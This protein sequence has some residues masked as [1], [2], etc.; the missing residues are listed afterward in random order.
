MPKTKRRLTKR[1]RKAIARSRAADERSR[2]LAPIAAIEPEAD[3]DDVPCV[4]E[5]V[6]HVGEHVREAGLALFQLVD[7]VHAAR[8]EWPEAPAV[9]ELRTLLEEIERVATECHEALHAAYVRCDTLLETAPHLH[10]VDNQVVVVAHDAT[11]STST[12]ARQGVVTASPPSISPIPA[13]RLA[14]E[15]ADVD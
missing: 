10:L 1:E 7:V 4:H 5:V 13:A 3:S 6:G 8:S 11:T 15:L 14:T 2:Q 9:A 12:S